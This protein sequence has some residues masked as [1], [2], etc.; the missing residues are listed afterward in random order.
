MAR[1]TDFRVACHLL[2]AGS[3]AVYQ[4]DDYARYR[5]VVEALAKCSLLHQR[6]DEIAF[7]FEGGVSDYF[8]IDTR[9]RDAFEKVMRQ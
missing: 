2:W 5:A 6:G 3:D 1:S 4:F 8:V 7:R 9:C